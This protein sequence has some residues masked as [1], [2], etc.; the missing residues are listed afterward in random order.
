MIKKQKIWESNFYY[1]TAKKAS[2][3]LTHPGLQLIK[4]QAK[5]VEKVL[6]VGCGEGTK[7]SKLTSKNNTAFGID[8]SKKAIKLAQKQYPHLQLKIADAENLPFAKDN[9]DLVF[10][11]FMLEHTVNPNKVIDEMI[12]VTK[13]GG[14]VII[15]A[16]NYGAPN[17]ASPCFK[18]S[19]TN[20]LL[21]GFLKD[22]YLLVFPHKKLDWDKV[23]P[24]AEKGEYEI[25]WDTTIEP[26]LGSL[27]RYLSQKKL[28]VSL[29]TSYWQEI[30]EDLNFVQRIF[31]LLDSLGIYPFVDW[32][33]H[34]LVITEKKKREEAIMKK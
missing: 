22:L 1:Q 33:P 29:A 10:S 28:K 20:K 26:Y 13:P 9:F 24:L 12:R 11:A 17:R 23:K 4:E 16:P 21:F 30:K 5:R 25:D 19:R 31:K 15:L 7:L 2:L 32:G 34:L 3:D 18:G 27:I 6:E 8:I 14:K